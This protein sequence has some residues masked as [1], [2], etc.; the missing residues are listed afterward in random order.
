VEEIIMSKPEKIRD[1]LR[2]AFYKK[3]ENT[4][5]DVYD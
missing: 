2:N 1:I 4:L 5:N 3:W